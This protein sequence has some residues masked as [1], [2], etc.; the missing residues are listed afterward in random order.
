MD[1]KGKCPACTRG[2][3]CNVLVTTVQSILSQPSSWRS[4]MYSAEFQVCAVAQH[5]VGG[6]IGSQCRKGH[7]GVL[8]ATCEAGYVMQSALC[9]ACPGRARATFFSPEMMLLSLAGLL[10]LS[11]V[12]FMFLTAPALTK[13]D[14]ESLRGSMRQLKMKKDKIRRQTFMSM[15]ESQD[16]S[17]ST[18]QLQQA[19][20]AVD[21]DGSG[22]IGA[23]EWK[24]FLG[25][26]KISSLAKHAETV[27][28]VSEIMEK[29]AP[30]KARRIWDMTS[31][32]ETIEAILK[33]IRNAIDMQSENYRVGNRPDLDTVLAIHRKIST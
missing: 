22:S 21:T 11:F 12:A 24:K 9:V 16:R 14:M 20:D 10:S 28:Q 4:S 5:C 19:F 33:R 8:C 7:T 13:K 29:M 30:V 1:E 2:C 26:D 17:F 32:L 18:F 3:D 23:Q 6:P 15:V 31:T 25:K 27:Q